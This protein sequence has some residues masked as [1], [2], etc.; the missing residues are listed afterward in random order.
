MSQPRKICVAICGLGRAGLIHIGNAVRNPR[1]YVKW[2]VEEDLEKADKIRNECFLDDSVQ[3]VKANGVNKVI[4]DKSVEV[5]IVCVPT[6]CHSSL[7]IAALK[8]GKAV[9]CEKPIAME[10]DEVKACYAAAKQYG[11]L[12]YC[13]FNR[14]FDPSIREVY[15]RVRAGE[16]GQVR[17]IKTTSR[18]YPQPALS[19]LKISGIEPSLDVTEYQCLLATRLAETCSMID[20]E[21]TKQATIEKVLQ[22][23]YGTNRCEKVKSTPFLSNRESLSSYPLCGPS[24]VKK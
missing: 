8:S 9:F 23:D 17:S 10:E 3:I 20:N 11:Q 22:T 24:L 2:I 12:L 15:M 7:I 13:A 5:V 4:E 19:F 14:R 6:A 21:V 18:D 16:I 1:V